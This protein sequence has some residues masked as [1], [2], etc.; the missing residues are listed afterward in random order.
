MASMYPEY[1]EHWNDNRGGESLA[2]AVWRETWPTPTVQDSANNGARSQFQRN[3]LPL[4]AAVK[5]WPTPVASDAG[6]DRGSSAG[7]GLRDAAGGSL[8]PTWVEWL[9]GYPLG[10]TEL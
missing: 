5:N 7:W 4:N 10:W 1:G 2:T 8:N 6:K 3:S 9:Q